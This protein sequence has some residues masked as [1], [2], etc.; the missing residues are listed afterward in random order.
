MANQSGCPRSRAL[1]EGALQSYE[2]KAGVT[3]ADHPLT[4][5][6]QSCDSI[7]SITA[8]LESQA[9]TF[10]EFQGRDRAMNAIRSTVLILTRLSATASLA[11]DIGLV[12]LQAL[13][14]CSTALM[15]FTAIPSR[16]SNTRWPRHPTCCMY[17][18]LRTCVGVLANIRVDQ[19]A[20]GVTSAYDALVDLL[21][22]IEHFLCRLD[23]YTRI[24][25]TLVMDEIV[26]KI[27]VELISTLA[28][29]TRELKQGRPSESVFTDL[30]P[31]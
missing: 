16:E 1:F 28:L 2:K 13:V 26:V 19:A 12:R 4:L 20:K 6:L 10:S 25:P 21:E 31:Y 9:Q 3:L 11:I 18:S 15:A 29:A 7:E 8:F 17:H 30:L 24:P 23:I 5:Q 27:M 14:A 22:S